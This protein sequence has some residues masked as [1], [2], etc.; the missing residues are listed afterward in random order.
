[1]RIW[2]SILQGNCRSI[3]E[4]DVRILN[5]LNWA[6]ITQVMVHFS[7]LLQLKL[8]NG[9]CLDFGTVRGLVF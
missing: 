7:R 2:T 9:L 5:H 1:M 6:S 3:G 8:F 4:F